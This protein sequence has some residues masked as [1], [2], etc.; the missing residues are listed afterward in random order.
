VFFGRSFERKIMGKQFRGVFSHDPALFAVFD[1]DEYEPVNLPGLE[2][3]IA[4]V[5][6]LMNDPDA[7]EGRA[8]ALRTGTAS[9]IE[10]L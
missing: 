2:R 5:Q 8:L 7:L 3:A 1:P 6:A 10:G 4:R 9:A